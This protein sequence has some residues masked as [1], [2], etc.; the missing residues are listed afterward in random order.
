MH[1]LILGCGSI[2]KR[3]IK[4]LLSIN[5]SFMIDCYDPNPKMMNKI[6][7]N[8][9]IQKLSSLPTTTLQYDC[10]L[11]CTPPSSHVKLAKFVARFHTPTFLEK[12]LASNSSGIKSLEKIVK[13]NKILFFVGYNFRFNDGILKVKELVD[14]KTLGNVIHAFAYYGQYLPDWRP[15]QNYKKNYS[16]IKKLGGNIIFDS[17]HEID[18]VSW[19]FGKPKYITSSAIKSNFL[20][21]NV[22]ALCD[23]IFSY[24]KNYQVSLHLDMIRRKYRRSLEIL[25]EHGIIEW[26]LKEKKIKIID[27]RKSK[28]RIISITEDINQMYIKELKHV[29]RCIKKQKKSNLID[30]SNGIQTFEICN[31]IERS[32]KK[33]KKIKV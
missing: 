28:P 14:K 31:A 10:V 24:S 20:K 32:N 8:K 9:N 16:F 13:K 15:Q 22:N 2:G 12:P 11:I 19:I 25:C 6:N 1:F 7:K 23:S 33:L 4:N 5:P 21:T 3:H 18:Y 27:A 30:L 26:N 17:S 29:I